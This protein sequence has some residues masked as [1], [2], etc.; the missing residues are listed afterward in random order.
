[1][2]QCLRSLQRSNPSLLFSTSI[3]QSSE[4]DA[5]YVPLLA[6]AV[7]SIV[8]GF[9]TRSN[10]AAVGK[11]RSWNNDRHS[12][13]SN[14]SDA[15]DDQDTDSRE[16]EDDM[17]DIVDPRIESRLL[18]RCAETQIRRRL[19]H[20]KTPTDDAS[21]GAESQTTSSSDQERTAKRFHQSLLDSSIEV[22]SVA[23]SEQEQSVATTRTGGSSDDI[24]KGIGSDLDDWL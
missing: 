1:M 4:R 22:D 23:I 12:T 17:S 9:E 5:R 16:S 15:E 21:V 10:G 6:T 24:G 8:L 2:T 18:A 19:E 20:T 14:E 3:L 13:G 11:L 7:T